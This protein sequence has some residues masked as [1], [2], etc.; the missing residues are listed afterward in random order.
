VGW[1]PCSVESGW[2]VAEITMGLEYFK[3]IDQGKNN[4]KK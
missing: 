2:S 4:D 1:G 3:Y